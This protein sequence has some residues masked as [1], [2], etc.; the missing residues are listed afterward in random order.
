MQHS[1]KKIIHVWLEGK[2]LKA[3]IFVYPGK[4]LPVNINRILFFSQE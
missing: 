2:N 4:N 3:E 1:M